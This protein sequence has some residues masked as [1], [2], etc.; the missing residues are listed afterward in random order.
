MRWYDERF[1]QPG[2]ILKNKM[3]MKVKVKIRDGWQEVLPVRLE[4]EN[5]NTSFIDESESGDEILGAI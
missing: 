5:E 1:G 2:L 3:Q 4:P